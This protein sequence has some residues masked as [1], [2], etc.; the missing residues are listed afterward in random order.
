M[1][2]PQQHLDGLMRIGIPMRERSAIARR[3]LRREG[4]VTLV[5]TMIATFILLVGVMAM[6]SLLGVA[7]TRNW[8]QGDRA[9][10]TTE[11]AQDKM[12]Q[13]EALSFAD[14]T[15]NT[16]VYPATVAG[17]TGL[18]VGGSVPPA[19]AVAGYVDYVDNTGTLQTT[20]AS[21][22]FIRQWSISMNAAGNLK[23]ITVVCTALTS[24]KGVSGAAASTTLVSTMSSIQ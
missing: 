9:T 7:V 1:A 19:A 18:S 20:A 13:L 23:T 5:E 21:A 24:S 8:G 10:R 2:V 11:D 15:T 16:T 12:E 4:G 6:M 17:G 22:S 3:S 14:T